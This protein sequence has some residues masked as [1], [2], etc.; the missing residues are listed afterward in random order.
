MDLE[1][2]NVDKASTRP[3][4]H[5]ENNNVEIEEGNEVNP[6]NGSHLGTGA[7]EHSPLLQSAQGAESNGGQVAVRVES[8]GAPKKKVL[9]GL[10]EELNEKV[11]GK[12]R[13][14]MAL[15]LAFVFIVSII[16]FIL[17]LCSGQQ[18][19]ADDNYDASLY[20]LPL[21]FNG[22]FRLANY[23]FAQDP[24]SE[25]SRDNDLFIKLEQ[26][27]TDVYKSSHVLERYFSLAKIHTVSHSKA[28]VQYELVFKMPEEH[29]QL[30]H[31]VLSR[32]I[33]YSV[34]VQQLLDQDTEDPLY[35]ESSSVS[36]Q[37]MDD[38]VS[39]AVLI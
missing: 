17:F 38:L 29:E 22:S 7:P 37:R 24:V 3:E 6:G 5:S 26:K 39:D 18:K 4:G 21:L 15:L 1:L 10:K 25:P 13:L 36:M 8:D 34:L 28:I 32:E 11:F 20:V 27:L 23:S 19:D 35:I 2:E 30:K 9:Q 12:I 16:L 31:Y 33:V 14:W